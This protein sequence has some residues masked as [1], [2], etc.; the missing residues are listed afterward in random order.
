MIHLSRENVFLSKENLSFLFASVALSIPAILID[1]NLLLVFPLIIIIMLSFV[2]GER[3]IISIVMIALFTLVG[4][5]TKSLRIVIQLSGIGVIS[6]LFLS[7]Y[8]LDFKNYR[9]IPKSLLYTIILYLFAIAV[10]SAMSD[11][12]SLGIPIFFRQFLFIVVVYLFYSLINN[13]LDIKNYINSIIIVALIIVTISLTYFIIEGFDILDLVSINRVRVSILI[14]NMEA[15]TNFYVISFPFIVIG[16]LIKKNLLNKYLYYF[17]TFYISLGLILTMSR[18]AF[19]GIAVST[20]I[21]LFLVRRK[22]FF[23]FIF[24]LTL[25]VLIFI[26]VKPLNELIY[27]VFRF[28]EGMSQRDL[29]WI[30][31]VDMIKDHVVFGIGPGANNYVMLNYFPYMLDDYFGKS[32]IYFAEISGGV[33]V[34]HNIFLAFFTEMGLLGLMTIIIIPVIFFIIGIKTIKKYRDESLDIYYLIIALFAAG[35]SVIFRNFF[36]S[37][38]ILYI[39]GIY[40]DLPF[41]LL[42]GSLIYFY[43]APL[44]ENQLNTVQNKYSNI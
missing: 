37:I 20:A 13:H 34:S 16:L 25:I 14:T 32:L 7:R 12:P 36:N 26:F 24:T 5:F 18:S 10:S 21:I 19:L 42:F 29:I 9:Q 33:N 40:T 41:W 30:M 15:L 2:Y 17:L 43:Y 4:E 22:L 3:F 23:S 39:G 8:G 27:L 1:H 31:S 38:G 6:Y 44:S 35:V 28:E 11:Y